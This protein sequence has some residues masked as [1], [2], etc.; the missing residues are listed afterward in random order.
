LPRVRLD[1]RHGEED[2]LVERRRDSSWL[3]HVHR[4]E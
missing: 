2:A 4:D 1:D 3:S